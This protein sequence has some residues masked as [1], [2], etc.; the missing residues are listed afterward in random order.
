MNTI[1]AASE[2][3]LLNWPTAVAIC[4]ALTALVLIFGVVITNKWPWDRD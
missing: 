4:F 1:I 3:E 2:P